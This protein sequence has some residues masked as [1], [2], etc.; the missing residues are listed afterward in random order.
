MCFPQDHIWRTTITQTS[1][2]RNIYAI[3]ILPGVPHGSMLGPLLYVLYLIYTTDIPVIAGQWSHSY[4]DLWWKS[5]YCNQ[6]LITHQTFLVTGTLNGMENYTEQRQICSYHFHH[7]KAT[8]LQVTL[9]SS[10]ILVKIKARYYLLYP[11]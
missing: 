4:K 7:K 1:V 6:N 2:M 9:I 11:N 10:S 8:C 3:L 5:Y